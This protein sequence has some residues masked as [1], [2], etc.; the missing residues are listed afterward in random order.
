MQRKIKFPFEIQSKIKFPLEIQRK[1][2]FP[3]KMQRKINF[4]WKCKENQFFFTFY[5]FFTKKYQKMSNSKEYIFKSQM[6]F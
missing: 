4:L 2:K 5:N 1:I 6:S 3:L